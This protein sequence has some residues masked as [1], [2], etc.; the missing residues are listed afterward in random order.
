MA[1]DLV[2]V[3]RLFDLLDWLLPK[4]EKFPRA[5]RF[6]LTQR[7]MNAAMDCVDAVNS[8]RSRRGEARRADLATADAALNRLRMYLRLAHRWQWLNDG[9]YEFVSEQ[10]AEV[11]R[12]LG[13]WIRQAG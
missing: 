11:G 4:S 6:T 7:M 2:L 10:V 3:S 12:L 9:Q 1:E 5:Y 8:A 13:G